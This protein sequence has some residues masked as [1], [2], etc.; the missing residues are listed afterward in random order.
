LTGAGTVTG[1]VVQDQGAAQ[2]TVSSIP[3]FS[4]SSGS[5]AATAIMCLTVNAATVGTGGATVVG[6][7]VNASAEDN[8]PATVAA[9]TN[10]DTQFGLVKIRKADVRYTVSAGS[11]ATPTVIYD[12]GIY[13]SLPTTYVVGNVSA[14]TTPPVATFAV[15]GVVDTSWVQQL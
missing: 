1:I 14:V 2:T 13:T 9:Y 3:T 8:F 11:I 12:G 10:P 6:A 15:G 5:V 7:F 4:Y